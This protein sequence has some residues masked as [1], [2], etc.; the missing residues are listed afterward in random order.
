MKGNDSAVS[1]MTSVLLDSNS[2]VANGNGSSSGGTAAATCGNQQG[3]KSATFRHE[4]E[5]IADVAVEVVSVRFMFFVLV[6]LQCIRI[7][8]HYVWRIW[9]STMSTFS[10]APV[11]IRCA[12]FV[13]TG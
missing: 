11:A 4:L 7:S 2:V 12:A 8:V 10:P 13:G 3:D 9:I 1:T 6:L 5:N